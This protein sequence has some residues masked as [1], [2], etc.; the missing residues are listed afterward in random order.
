MK[1]VKRSGLSVERDNVDPNWLWRIERRQ[2]SMSGM[3]S[4]CI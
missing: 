2:Y 1:Q 4:I 3:H